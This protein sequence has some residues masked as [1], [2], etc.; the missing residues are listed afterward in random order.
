MNVIIERWFPLQPNAQYNNSVRGEVKM[1]IS[2]RSNNIQLNVPLISP[3]LDSSLQ[4]I[5]EPPSFTCL[6]NVEHYYNP[7]LYNWLGLLILHSNYFYKQNSNLNN[8][9]LFIFKINS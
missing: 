2:S 9:S 8:N 4:P 1:K 5:Y 7:P 6:I 3:L